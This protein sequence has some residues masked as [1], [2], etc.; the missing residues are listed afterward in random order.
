MH[1]T[2]PSGCCASFAWC[3]S[4]ESSAFS[5]PGEP[6]DSSKGGAVETGCSDLY[7]ATYCLLASYCR[8]SLHP[9]PTAPPSDECREP[10]DPGPR[11][12]VLT[13][14]VLADLGARAALVCWCTGTGC[15]T[16]RAPIRGGCACV[17]GSCTMCCKHGS[18]KLHPCARAYTSAR[19][20]RAC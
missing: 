5:G 2:S 12:T 1:H 20:R 11:K 15:T 7:H 4:S 18:A 10:R 9:P 6:Q 19:S 16:R 17:H 3:A 8:H 13:E 14:T